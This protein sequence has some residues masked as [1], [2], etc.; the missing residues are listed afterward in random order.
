M[1]NHF[2]QILAQKCRLSLWITI[3]FLMTISSSFAQTNLITNGDFENK[4][5][6]W[7]VWGASLANSTDKHSGTSAALVS[8]RKN[9]W[10]AIAQD[11]KSVIVN[12][13]TY[14]L[15]AWIKNPKPAI[16]LRATIHIKDG[17]KDNY[18]GLFRTSSPVIGSYAFYTETFTITWTG[19]LAT[20]DLYFETEAVGGVYSDYLIDDVQLVKSKPIVDVIQE[21]PGL[22]DI[23]S[24]MLI[25]GCIGGTKNYFNN[26]AAKA[27]VLKDCN[28]VTVTCYPG[29]GRWDEVKHHVYHVDEFT[30]NAQEMKKQHMNVT[31]HMLLGWDQ[32]FPEWYKTG[33]FPADTLDAI[34]KSWLKGIIQ[35]KGNDTLVD[36]WNIVNEAI[37]WDGK[38][39]YWP[40]NNPNH[41]DACE[42]QNMGFEADASGLTGKDFVNAQH[43]V[44]IRKSFEYARTLT[45]KKLELRD[46][47]ME[48]PNNGPK[49]TAFYQLAKHLKNMNAPV[50]AI[51]FQTHIDL[52]YNYDWEAYTNNIKRYVKLGYEVNIPEVDIGDVAKSWSEYKAELQKLQYYKLVTAAIR[53]GASQ[54]Q[55]W[56]FIDDNEDW[57]KGMSAFPY[58]NQFEAKPSYY[59]IKE[60]L[61]DMS[62]MLYWE[63]DAPE[64]NIMPDVMKYNNFGTLKNISTPVIVAGFKAK[65]LQFDGLDDYISSG[66]LSSTISGNLSF[67]CFLKTN[68]TKTEI[69]ADL[70]Q[71]GVSGLKIG[72]NADGKIYLNAAEAGLAV[73]LV[74]TTIINDNNWHFIGIRRD[75]TSYQLY[76]DAST[77]IASGQ[78]TLQKCDQLT[79]GAKTDG[80]TPFEGSIDEVKLFDSAVDEGSF[81]RNYAPINPLKL[82][83][84]ATGLKIRLTWVDKTPDEKG[85]IVERKIA[86]GNWEEYYRLPANAIVFVED[87][88]SYNTE[89]TYRVCAFNEISKSVPTNEVVY[90]TPKDPTAVTDQDMDHLIS[91]FPNPAHNQ[92]TIVSSGN[93]A[94]KIYDIQGCL[95]FE[96]KKCSASETIDLSSFSSGIY[97]IQARTNE[98]KSLL[99]VVKN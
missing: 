6:G 80:T 82:T 65:A 54:M 51:G 3:L 47:G 70:A 9:P 72:I 10:D 92:F 61:I 17:S 18:I 84:T 95:M 94:L 60:A 29:W 49:F 45:K 24:T 67:S 87:L 31:A 27:Q 76:V 12:G 66:K 30:K 46:S 98:R 42:M 85:F 91:V 11:I 64:N 1:K 4:T 28:V 8:N 86:N 34:M 83:Y 35:Y 93:P 99:K 79:V 69:I 16:N 41:N 25:G 2:L 90:V 39:G 22:K 53:G 75:S 78:G 50:D 37:S 62:S 58:T 96:K 56:G 20:A 38:G 32:Y 74:D 15:S 48:F 63:M 71:E 57:R 43:P 13:E 21:G 14:T 5:T 19:N 81:F 23:K 73:A 40:R 33:D 52:E 89:Y 59:G 44:Y 88:K 77:P 97:F 7:V 68:S 55:T 36:T 26:A